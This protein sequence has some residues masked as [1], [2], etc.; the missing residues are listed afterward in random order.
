MLESRLGRRSSRASSCIHYQPKVSLADG[1]VIGVEALLRWYHPDLGL[2]PP[3]EFIPLAEETGLIVPIGAWVLRTACAQVRRWQRLGHAG[4]SSRSTSR[5]ASSR[6]RTWWPRSPPRSRNRACA[7]DLLELELTESVI[8][9]DAP[10]AAQPAASELTALG[11]RLA[12]RRF[13]HRLLV[14]RL[15]AGLSRSSALKIDRSFV[16]DIDRDPNSAALAQAIIAMA[17]SLQAQ[18]GGRRGRDPRAAGQLLR[19]FGCQ[20][21]QGY[22]F[23]RPLPPDELLALLERAG[24]C[25]SQD[26]DAGRTPARGSALDLGPAGGA[27]LGR[28]PADRA[29]GADRWWPSVQRAPEKS[30]RSRSAPSSMAP[31]RSTPRRLA[32]NRRA[33]R[34][35]APIEL[36]AGQVGGGEVGLDQVGTPVRLTSRSVRRDELGAPRLDAGQV[37]AGQVG[38]LERGVAQVAAGQIDVGQIVAVEAGSGATARRV[39]ARRCRRHAP[40]GASTPWP[41]R[42]T[43]GE[44]QHAHQRAQSFSNRSAK[45]APQRRVEIRAVDAAMPSACERSDTILADA[46]GDDARE[47]D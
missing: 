43:D 32:W 2:V 45:L 8:M 47:S 12:D 29:L 40:P 10:E 42:A 37:G 16:R 13:R 7:A 26:R 27:P 1:A 34:R 28:Q 24:G 9:R 35:L 41:R 18:G 17:A 30:A 22:I 15:P 39:P 25:R 23:S 46:A 33:P 38:A 4:W 5:P 20:E 44:C 14:A 3:A 21:M 36:G 11:M 31:V 19:R 6:R